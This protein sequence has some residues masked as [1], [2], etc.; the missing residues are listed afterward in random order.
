MGVA[1]LLLAVAAA[2]E[3]VH[4]VALDGAGADEG[5]LDG[6]VV[7]GL[8]LHAGQGGHLGPRLHLEHPHGVGP[9]EHLVHGRLLGDGGQV[10]AHP[11]HLLDGVHRQVQGVEHAQAE[12]VELDDA[13]GGAVVLVPLQHRAALHA[14]PLQGHHLPQR[15]VGDHHA[16]GVDAQ[17]AGEAVEAAAGV[18]DQAAAAAGGEVHEL[19]DGLGAAGVEVLGQAVHLGLGEPEGLAHVLEHRAGPVGDHVGHHGRPLPP[20]A[21]VA[22]LDDLLAPLRLE[23]HVDVGRPAPLRRQEPLEGQAEADGVHPGDPQAAAHR[24]VGARAAD[25]AVDALSPGEAHDVPHHQ[26][27]A[28][29][30]Q[31]ADH[32][33]LV[34]QAGQG[35]RVDGPRALPRVHLPGPLED[36]VAQVV[37]LAAEGPRH[38]EVG[39]AGGHQAQVEG[40]G[41]PQ[42]GGPVH[43]PRV[44]GEAAGHLLRGLQVAL[45]GGRPEGV[46]LL[47]VAPPPDGGQHLGQAGLGAVVVVHVVGGHQGQAQA[48]R[49]LGEQVV[50]GFVFGHAVVPHL[51]EEAGGEDLRRRAAA[52]IAPSR[53]PSWAARGTAP[54]RHP[55]RATRRPA[56]E[57][58]ARS[59]QE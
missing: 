18:E 46:P 28:G 51:H 45:V 19:G 35:R 48:A 42:V 30:A 38:G 37:H 14:P 56:A 17:V 5:H 15:P 25:L 59:S 41:L 16:A 22:V 47:Q 49:H 33:Q 36:Q 54:C 2:Q 32:R 52:R 9:G 26:E 20:V 39:Q 24:R 29:E 23:V 27:V 58:S 10:E 44:A 31:F 13:H 11:V 7:E 6:Q 21:L 50:A 57:A 3:G 43:R 8:R 55:V 12:Q 4:R 40:Q 53:S 1:H 34:L